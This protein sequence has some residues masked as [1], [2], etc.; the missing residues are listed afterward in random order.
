MKWPQDADGW[1][2]RDYSQHVLCRPH[3]WHVQRAGQG[4]TLLLIHGAGGATQSWRTL[5]PLLIPDFDVVAVD[6]PGQ[7]FTRSGAH[8]RHG[9]NPMAEDLMSLITHL[10]IHPTAL[11]GHSAGVAIAM[12]MVEIGC[13][14]KA[15]FGINAALGNFEGVAGWL[16]P[17]LAKALAL[18]PFAANVFAATTTRSS[19]TQLLAGTGSNIDE[20]GTDLY[21]RL[22]K[23]A[24]HVDGTLSMMAQWSLDDLLNRVGQ[25]DTLTHLITGSNDKA[26]PPKVSVSINERLPNST[27]TN[28]PNLGH[29]AHEEDPSAIAAWLKTHLK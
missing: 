9:L 17:F 26:V 21:V 28:L 13:D 6:L 23:D 16:F 29:L 27:L 8:A 22:A 19:V 11:I 25:F 12:R 18:T 5:F 14:V 3:R 4:P 1:P 20:A 7:G 24:E 10:D 15:V 2:M